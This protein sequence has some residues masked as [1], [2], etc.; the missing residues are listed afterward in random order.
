MNKELLNQEKEALAEF[1]RNE[2]VKIALESYEEASIRGMCREGAWEY[3]V[4]SMRNLK[5]KELLKELKA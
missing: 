3:A 4:D 1:I 5:I 2:C